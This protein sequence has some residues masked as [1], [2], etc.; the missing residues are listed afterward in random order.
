M[1]NLKIF[2]CSHGKVFTL[3]SS[4]DIFERVE[5]L[6]SSLSQ[7][8]GRVKKFALSV[9]IEII[10]GAM[11]YVLCRVRIYDTSWSISFLRL[12]ASRT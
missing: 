9:N 11:F 3:T 5:A 8:L 2:G 1:G 6:D 4:F 10:I 7:A 12:S